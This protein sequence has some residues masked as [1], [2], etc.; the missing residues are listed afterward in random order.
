MHVQCRSRTIKKHTGQ[1]QIEQNCLTV[2]NERIYEFDD[3][4]VVVK[5]VETDFGKKQIVNGIA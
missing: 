2:Q 3:R 4:V 5:S 1:T